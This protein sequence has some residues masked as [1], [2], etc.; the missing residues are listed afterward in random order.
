MYIGKIGEGKVLPGDYFKD[1]FISI[2]LNIISFYT[3]YFIVP[4]IVK[5][6]KKTAMAGLILFT[7]GLLVGLR[8][9]FS[10]YFWKLAGNI[11]KEE[12]VIGWPWVW[13]ELR[14]VIITGIYAILIYYFIK[15]IETEKLRSDLVQQRQAGELALLKS[16]V[17]PHFLFNTLNNIYSL[18]YQKSDE[19][20]EAVMKFS[21]IMRYVLYD[22]RTEMV[23]L[24]KEIEYLVS[25]IELQKLRIR[26]PD[27]VLLKVEGNC[28]GVAIAPMLL[29]P[30]VENAF[31][32]A[33]KENIPAITVSLFTDLR[34]IR[35]EVSNYKQSD[36]QVIEKQFSGVGIENIRRRLE[37]IYPGRHH[38]EI[39]EENNQFK[40]KLEIQP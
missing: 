2:L 36:I 20:P 11:P 8:I 13:N 17:N 9:V 24:D 23:L 27:F 12:L 16:Q 21:S 34:Y 35:F 14:L 33:G 5:Y 38:L 39:K 6:S 19:A 3:I 29:I 7:I 18:V 4:R 25:Y 31:K 1:V 26:E 28:E 30:F 32:H 37:L 15:A 40:V 10:Y 22:S